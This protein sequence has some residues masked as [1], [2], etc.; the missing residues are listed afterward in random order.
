MI[1]TFRAAIV[2]AVFATIAPCVHA[3]TLAVTGGTVIDGTGRDP[4]ENG[5]VLISE[6][7][8]TV[9]G[10]SWDVPI[11]ESATR[12]DA[13]GKYVIPGL[14]DA[15][16]HLFFPFT[17][18]MLVRYED[19]YDEIV[20][21]AA[22]IALKFGLTTVFDT[23]GNREALVKTRN[24]I[25]QGQA[26]GC[27]IF[28]AGN[29]IGLDGPLTLEFLGSPPPLMASP[30]FVESINEQWQQGVGRELRWMG[31]EQVRALVGEY[32]AG[33]VDFLKYAS[34]GHSHN[35]ENLIAFSPRVQRVIVDE[36]HRTGK[37]VQA[38][39]TSVESLD[40]AIEAGVDII[41]HGDISGPS[42]PIPQETIQKLLDR[43][44]TVS[45]MP[46]TQRRLDALLEE[47]SG[48]AA[49][50]EIG[51]VNGANMIRAGVRLM[52]STDATLYSPVLAPVFDQ[53][54]VDPRI[55]IGEGHFNAI[56]AL[57]ERGMD[58][59][60]LL[61]SAT[62][63]I[64]RGYKRD[65]DLGTLEAGKIADLVILDKNPLESAHNYRSI[66]AVIKDGRIIDRDALPVAPMI[67]TL[68]AP[69]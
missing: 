55:K 33:D 58:P 30:G 11:P 31:P 41:T 16:V 20:L 67:S 2:L 6:N 13:S 39:V 61:K 42:V 43:N 47:G 36:A 46:V 7:R 38:H 8:I 14:M 26:P 15:N 49:Y 17:L 4:I 18:E 29:I 62:S 25:N 28:I 22:Q 68:T 63:N 53:P 1:K 23:W 9:V 24:V 5:V 44:I 57:E 10:A 32:A 34:S 12:I 56:V 35:E 3:E 37:T 45:V 19:R 66:H 60:E 65:A 48:L 40:L 21:E 50:F 52:M 69:D 51:K 59:M 64:A 54:A 27:R